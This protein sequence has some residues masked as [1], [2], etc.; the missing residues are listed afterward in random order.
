MALLRLETS[1]LQKCLTGGVIIEPFEI[2]SSCKTK[3]INNFINC[4]KH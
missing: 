3:Q 1:G 2:P 4:T